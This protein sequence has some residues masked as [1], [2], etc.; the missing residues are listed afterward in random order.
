MTDDTAPA[1]EPHEGIIDRLEEAAIQAELETGRREE[2]REQAQRSVLRRLAII[3]LG[4]T[5]IVAGAVMVITPGPGWITIAAGL[6]VLSTE[7]AWADRALRFVRRNIPGVPEDGRIPR[8][9]W[10]TIAVMTLAT[11]TASIWWL[12]R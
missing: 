12:T 7:V 10:L 8:S 9:A 6:G 5:M 11:T 4:Y 2:T 3:L 1:D